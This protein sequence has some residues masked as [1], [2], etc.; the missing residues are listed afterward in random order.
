MTRS[1][2]NYSGPSR[3]I[4]FKHDAL[5]RVK[6]EKI[7]SQAHE[8][9]TAQDLFVYHLPKLKLNKGQRAAVPIFTT[10]VPYRHLYTWDLHLIH[11]N[12]ENTSSRK[13]YNHH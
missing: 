12:T 7:S 9:T 1:T 8:T 11:K 10:S 2:R 5:G 13:K 4:R 3:E 6:Q